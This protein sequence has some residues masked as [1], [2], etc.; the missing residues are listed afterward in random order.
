MFGT[1]PC[2]VGGAGGGGGLND[3]EVFGGLQL[4]GGWLKDFGG[5]GGFFFDGSNLGERP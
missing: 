4:L 1:P 2:S 3:W 5:W